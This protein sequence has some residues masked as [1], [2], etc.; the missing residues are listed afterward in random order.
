MR[1]RFWDS[2][3][4]G[5]L[6][7]KLTV[8]NAL[9]VVL[10]NRSENSGKMSTVIASAILDACYCKSPIHECPEETAFSSSIIKLG[11]WATR[12]CN[13]LEGVVLI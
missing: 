9:H 6:G 12:M 11:T 7:G 3:A 5:T 10:M 13:A 2:A 8:E 1:T 4:L